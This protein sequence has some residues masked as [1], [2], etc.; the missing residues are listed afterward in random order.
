MHPTTRHHAAN[1]FCS[2]G[3]FFWFFLEGEEAD[4]VLPMMKWFLKKNTPLCFEIIFDSQEITEIVE[5]SCPPFT[6]LPL[7]IRSYGI[8]GRWPKPGKW[9]A[10]THSHNTD[11]V[12]TSPVSACCIWGGRSAEL[13]EVLLQAQTMS[14]HSCP[15]TRK[16]VLPVTP[17]RIIIPTT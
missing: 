6:Q 4:W 13:H 3:F 10:M 14:R 12:P 11:R 2:S 9:L 1:A 5:S 16:K 7:L 15:I 8:I 17:F